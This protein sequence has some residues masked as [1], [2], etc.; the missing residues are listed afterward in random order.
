MQERFLVANCCD[1]N[2][3]LYI[4]DLENPDNGW[5][6]IHKAHGVD[7]V[8]RG[9]AFRAFFENEIITYQR[10]NDKIV[11]LG[12]KPFK[13]P[14][15]HGSTWDP[16]TDCWVVTNCGSNTLNWFTNI[17]G[18]LIKTHP[19]Q[20]NNQLNDVL[21]TKNGY[22]VSSFSEGIS[23]IPLDLSGI[24]HLYPG[25]K[26]HAICYYKNDIW[27]CNSNS[28]EVMCNGKIWREFKGYVRGLYFITF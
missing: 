5:D 21:W 6:N 26:S 24:E 1:N 7:I 28:G 20:I 3:G 2:T 25:K 4:L 8:K 15:H 13:L 11:K 22:L 10:Q 12:L 23:R 27:W 18:K 16:E 9:F 17:T 19:V 14:G